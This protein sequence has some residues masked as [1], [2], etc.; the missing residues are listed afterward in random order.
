MNNRYNELNKATYNENLKFLNNELRATKAN[1][2]MDKVN[3]KKGITLNT[4]KEVQDSA[5]IFQGLGAPLAIKE[6][7]MRELNQ[8]LE[9]NEP[10]NFFIQNASLLA[11]GSKQLVRTRNYVEEIKHYSNLNAQLPSTEKLIFAKTQNLKSTVS[12]STELGQLQALKN[13]DL[14]INQISN[15]ED[16]YLLTLRINR[17]TFIITKLM[18]DLKYN[19]FIWNVRLFMPKRILKAQPF[20]KVSYMLRNLKKTSILRIKDVLAK[21]S[22]NMPKAKIEGNIGSTGLEI[23]NKKKIMILQKKLIANL[24]KEGITLIMN[25]NYLILTKEEYIKNINEMKNGGIAKATEEILDANFKKPLPTIKEVNPQILSILKEFELKKKLQPE[26]KNARLFKETIFANNVR[27]PDAHADFTAMDFFISGYKKFF[28]SFDVKNTEAKE[29]FKAPNLASLPIT[30]RDYSPKAVQRLNLISTSVSENSSLSPQS[31]EGESSATATTALA[32]SVLR[33]SSPLAPAVQT[34]EAT[35]TASQN[36]VSL[37]Q[38]PVLSHYLKEMSI[39]NM[40]SKGIFIFYYILIGFHFKKESNKIYT[41]G[42]NIYN[43][44]EA[45]FKSMYCLISKPV[46]ITTPD[47]IIVQLFYYLIIPNVLK[48]KKFFNLKLNPHKRRTNGQNKTNR[49]GI[50]Q[51]KAKSPKNKNK[52]KNHLLAINGI[53]GSEGAAGT[54]RRKSSHLG[55]IL[56]R[57]K[58][59]Q[60]ES[61]KRRKSIKKQYNKFRKIKLSVR[62]KLRKLSNISLVKIY[63]NKF[64]FLSLILNNIFKKPVEFDLIRTHYP[65][66]DSNILVNLLGIMINKIKL[67]I[68]IRRL[69]EKTII[70]NINNLKHNRAVLI[71]A[72]LSGMTIRVAGR[73][74][75]HKIVPKQT[76]K[77]IRRG[78]SATGKVNF[79]DI[80]TYTNKNKRGAFSITVKAGHN[81]F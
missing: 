81:F 5:R 58:L 26:N 69:F 61:L 19:T 9:L 60:E 23:L 47:K 55:L 3:I 41:S 32:P 44:L 4:E 1:Q 73:L 46:F 43:L 54:L 11:K 80:A 12:L 71:P 74:L 79:K 30:L 21:G 63:P 14:G 22:L 49:L 39:Y 8:N 59:R 51:S 56:I 25:L 72:F 45:S 37:V 40:R 13:Q 34:S 52:N 67:R 20:V 42:K 27:Q 77:T 28:G 7:K 38:R 50:T 36:K 16:F 66:Y 75:T 29:G 18:L 78:S 10:R 62:V 64:K 48:L 65:Y 35:A 68:I 2:R 70:Q 76:V 31:L 6:N 15:K 53:K 24:L 33:K 17:Y 57:K